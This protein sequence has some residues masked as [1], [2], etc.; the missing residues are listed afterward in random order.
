L[1]DIV[2]RA[3]AALCGDGDVRVAFNAAPHE[4]RGIPALSAGTVSPATGAARVVGGSVLEND[5]I[6]VE[7]D[8]DGHVTSLFDLHAEREVIPPGSVGN[9]LQLH[10]DLPNN[11][12]AWDVDP[13]YRNARQDLSSPESITVLSNRPKEAA[14]RAQYRFGSSRAVQTLRLAA[15]SRAL[16]VDLE[17]DWRE[18]DRFLKVALPIDLHADRSSSEIQFGHIQRPTHNNTS[19]DAARFEFVAHRFVHVGEP[20]Y[21]VA[22]VNDGIY[23][24][25]VGAMERAGG[26]RATLARLS[27]LRSPSF[28]DLRGENG[29]HNFRYAILPGATV[30]DAVRYGYHFNPSLRV[31]IAEDEVRPLISLDNAAVVVE[32]VKAADDRTGDVVVRY[33][34]SLGGRASTRRVSLTDLL[35]RRL[36]ELDFTSS[37]IASLPLRPFQIVTLRLSTG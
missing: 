9:V 4:Q 21:G 19:W 29:V 26:G 30:A 5:F 17:V 12:P 37:G 35:E 10:P 22:V 34:E 16:V 27:I 18:H 8:A 1:E 3:I 31:A 13:F 15:N 20:G 11:W 14:V 7:I 24:H 23:G 6:R 33:Y 36:T 28:A 2:E 32:A 25:E